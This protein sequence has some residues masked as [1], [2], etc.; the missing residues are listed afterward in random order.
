MFDK[1]Q[2]KPADALAWP[3]VWTF[4]QKPDRKKARCVV[5]GSKW[6]RRSMTLGTTYA[7]SLAT[8]SK[9]LFWAIAAKK[10]LIVVGADV[11]NAFAEAPAPGDTFYIIPD[12]ILHDWWVNHKK[13]PPIPS[14]WVLKVKYALQG[15]PESPRL[16]QRHIKGILTDRIGYHHMHHEPSL[17]QVTINDSW[18]MLLRQVDD[19]AFAVEMEDIGK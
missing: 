19:F 4:L 9:R 12:V 10:G 7:N 14:G 2:P 8:D 6:W 18:T 5:D 15:H 3:L 17:Y 11:S 13:C 16:W 1:P